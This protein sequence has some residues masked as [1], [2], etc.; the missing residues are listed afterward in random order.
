MNPLD[1]G[2]VFLLVHEDEDFEVKR[3][4]VLQRCNL[5]RQKSPL[6]LLT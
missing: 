1:A 4:L 2:K 6:G 5:L 3:Q